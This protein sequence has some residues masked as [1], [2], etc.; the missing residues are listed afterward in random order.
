[1]NQSNRSARRGVILP[2]VALLSVFLMVMMVFFVDV[3]YMQLTRTQLQATTDAAAKAACEALDAGLTDAQVKQIAIDIAAANEVAGQPLTLE[4]EDV[5]LGAS[6]QQA[7]GSWA[8]TPGATPF[9]AVQVS[10]VKSDSKPSGSVPLFFAGTIGV[11]SFSPATTA[12]ASQFE[13]QVV[14]CLDRSHSMCFDLTGVDW[15]YPG[16]DGDPNYDT[17]ISD[18][19]RAPHVSN[20]RW[21]AL[22]NGINAFLNIVEASG[23]SQQQTLSLVT[24]GSDLP[25]DCDPAVNFV[26]SRMEIPLGFDFQGIRNILVALGQ[27]SMQGATNMSAGLD[28]AIGELTGPNASDISKKTIILFTDGQ[29]NQG[30]DPATRAATAANNDITIHVVSL[31][32]GLDPAEMDAIAGA[33]GGVH[34]QASTPQELVDA[35]QALAR[36]LPVVLTK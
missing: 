8:F 3:A 35:F 27:E 11:N 28:E 25:H 5:V 15:S 22:Y 1:M 7:V 31:L 16:P 34:Y 26:A 20:S 2:L 32:D 36:S 4:P 24:W 29:W 21:A 18:L 6:T 23:A 17:S 19:C 9:T 33:T 30:D 14:I 10:G 13:H 12:E